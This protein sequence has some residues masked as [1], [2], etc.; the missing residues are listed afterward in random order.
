MI[1][2]PLAGR[3]P[4]RDRHVVEVHVAARLEAIGRDDGD[5]AGLRRDAAPGPSPPGP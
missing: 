1:G 2:G 4:L 5:L 3:T